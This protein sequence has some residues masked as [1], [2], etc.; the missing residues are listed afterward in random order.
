MSPALVD[1]LNS[2]M[3]DGYRLLGNEPF[4]EW[5][6]KGLR[7]KGELRSWAIKEFSRWDWCFEW[8]GDVLEEG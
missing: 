1:F 6:H 4:W 3:R 8:R 7:S 5:F 2:G